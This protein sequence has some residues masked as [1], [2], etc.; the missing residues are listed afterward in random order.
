MRI[1]NAI[2]VRTYMPGRQWIVPNNELINK[3][4]T[5]DLT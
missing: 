5:R 2:T 3:S 4:D 1:S